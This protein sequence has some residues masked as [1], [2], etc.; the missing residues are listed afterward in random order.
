MIDEERV[1]LMTKMQA[2]E[3]GPGKRHVAIA[4]YFRGDY[5]GKQMLKGGISVTVAL[6]V[7]YSA[8]ILY[9]VEGFMKM[10]YQIDLLEYLKE[11]S[12]NYLKIVV[13]YVLITYLVYAYRYA[14]AKKGLKEYYGN[15]KKLSAMYQ[16]E[17]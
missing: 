13:V 10:L 16:K 15:L 17:M 1:K 8:S 2:Y 9:D 3:D 4:N 5:L 14:K 12:M 6:I 11:L 7:L